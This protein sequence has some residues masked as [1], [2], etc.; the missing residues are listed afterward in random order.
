MKKMLTV[1]VTAAV[2]GLSLGVG[3]GRGASR[4]KLRNDE[5][6]AAKASVKS[7]VVDP[8]LVTLS[9]EL[10]KRGKLKVEPLK[11]QT[12]SSNL[13][14]VGSVNFDANRM[15]EV[16]ARIESRV[17][18][19]MV[20]KGDV[21]KKGQPLVEVESSELGDAIATLLSARANLI[22]AEHNERRESG[23]EK[24]QLSSAAVVERARAEVKALRAE[25]H[26]GEQR[27][28]AMGVT[29]QELHAIASG[30]APSHIT[31]RAPLNGEV[32]GR[33][34]VLG[35]VVGPTDPVLRIADLDTVWVEL[36]VFERDLARVA[37]GNSASIESETHPGKVF[38]GHVSHV[39]ATVDT[40]TRTAQVRIEV[41]NGGRLLRPGQ[42][43]RARLSTKGNERAV[44]GVPRT[45]VLQVEGE[46]S[47]FVA[48]GNHRYAARPVE[49]GVGEGEWTEIVRGLAEGDM[50]VTEGG[51][52]LKSELLR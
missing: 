35:Q 32:V 37:D 18:R 26:G 17:T 7:S 12:M 45:A 39:D 27:L 21:V 22:A 28:L 50:I 13:R 43:V 6:E 2:L 5:N 33:Y 16:G 40:N 48:L 20:S 42:F 14:L 29:K 46:P 1:G 41:E 44:L 51:F 38:K 25:V 49:L 4:D 10:V 30:N 24:Q 19:I 9:P 47:V 31:L 36:D 8:R 52:V 34:A 3:L 23:L 11:K 15:S